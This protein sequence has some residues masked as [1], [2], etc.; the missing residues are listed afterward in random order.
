MEKAG[1]GGALFRNLYRDFLKE[2]Y[3]LL[4]LDEIKTGHEAFTEV[5]ELWTTVSE[6]FEKVS[7]T[8]AM[9]YIQQTSDL[10]RIISEKEKK[11]ME[12]LA[13]L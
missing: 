11:A 1:T 5:A 3:E 10:L 13:V 2:S 12:T 9:E 8:K 7:Q 4:Q 6:F